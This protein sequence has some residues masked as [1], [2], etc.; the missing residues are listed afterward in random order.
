MKARFRWFNIKHK[1]WLY[2]FYFENRW[3]WYI[4][5]GNILDNP[6]HTPDDFE[7][8]R[9]SVWASILLKDKNGNEIY[10]GDIITNFWVENNMKL[11]KYEVK[12][13]EDWARF[14]LESVKS[15]DSTS[16]DKWSS[17]KCEIIWNIYM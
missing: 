11:R 1:K 16:I 3:Y 7:V 8:D 9:K 13:N 10:Q 4:V 15:K 6:F 12:L 2:W 5:D 14:Y 17:I